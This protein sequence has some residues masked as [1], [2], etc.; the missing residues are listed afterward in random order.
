MPHFDALKICSCG[1]HCEKMQQALSPFLTIFSTL[2]G[3]YFPFEM[4]LKMSSAICFNLDQSQ[5]SLSGN[6]LSKSLGKFLLVLPV[7]IT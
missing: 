7:F 2:Y 1:K 4:H 6:G 3:T 5:I